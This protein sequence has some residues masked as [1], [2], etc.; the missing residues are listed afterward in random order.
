MKFDSGYN[1]T[2]CN[3][4]KQNTQPAIYNLVLI[5]TYNFKTFWGYMV[6]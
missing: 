3:H 4:V 5:E 1:A 6:K 2:Q